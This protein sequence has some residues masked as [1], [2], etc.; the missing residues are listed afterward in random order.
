MPKHTAPTRM[1]YKITSFSLLLPLPRPGLWARTLATPRTVTCSSAATSLYEGILRFFYYSFYYSFYYFRTIFLLFYCSLLF[2]LL[3][4]LLFFYYFFLLF[5]Y[6]FFY[7]SLIS[8]LKTNDKIILFDN[9]K[10]YIVGLKETKGKNA[11]MFRM[12][13]HTGLVHRGEIAIP[14]GQLDDL[15]KEKKKFA[16]FELRLMFDSSGMEGIG[17]EGEGE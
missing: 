6:Y 17:R 14:K 10:R 13:F 5:F 4:S 3:F 15:N 11:R 16:D 9:I 1:T 12:Q 2:L 7:F 8:L